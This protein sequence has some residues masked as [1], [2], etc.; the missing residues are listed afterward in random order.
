MD[1]FLDNNMTAHALS[2]ILYH[3]TV[4]PRHRLRKRLIYHNRHKGARQME[5]VSEFVRKYNA[6]STGS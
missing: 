5:S 6:V 1:Q 3:G 2:K 4:Y